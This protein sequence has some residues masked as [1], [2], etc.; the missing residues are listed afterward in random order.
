MKK[1]A[2]SIAIF[3]DDYRQPSPFLVCAAAFSHFDVVRY[4]IAFLIG[5]R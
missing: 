3:A 2:F 4:R 1:L 5:A